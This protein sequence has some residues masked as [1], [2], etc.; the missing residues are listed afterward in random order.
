MADRKRRTI[1]FTVTESEYNDISLCAQIKG[2]GGRSPVSSFAHHC[3]INE[4][5]I[6]KAA[7]EGQA[8]KLGF[9]N[10][11]ILQSEDGK[12]IKIGFSTSRGAKKRILEIQQGLPFRI[13]LLIL[14]EN[15]TFKTEK[16]L[17]KKYQKHRI[18]GEWFKG[19]ILPEL[20]RDFK[21][22]KAF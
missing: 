18:R 3:L 17:H 20:R 19:T 6:I 16:E 21:I 4:A 2:H 14:I 1:S 13:K 10:V 5:K 11:Y 8:N 22:I 15:C 7:D 9:G 12:Y